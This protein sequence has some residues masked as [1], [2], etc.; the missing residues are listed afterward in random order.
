MPDSA[1]VSMWG[2]APGGDVTPA[3][4]VCDGAISVPGPRLDV[5]VGDSS[6]QIN[7]TNTLPV[8]VSI[9]IPGRSRR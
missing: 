4:G 8:P 1:S 9:V 7:L 3:D 5:P 6:L 2:F